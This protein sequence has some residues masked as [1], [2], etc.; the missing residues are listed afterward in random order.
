MILI[1]GTL[2]RS[3][4]LLG[5]ACLAG[6]GFAG[7]AFAERPD[8]VPPEQIAAPQGASPGHVAKMLPS[9]GTADAEACTENGYAFLEGDQVPQNEVRAFGYFV[10]GC[11]F[12]SMRGCTMAG[13][14]Y[15]QGQGVV[16]NPAYAASYYHRACE[17]GEAI[18]SSNLGLAYAGGVG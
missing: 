8:D 11:E 6:T 7:L 9:C 5:L 1:D 14:A 4:L 2:R 13:Y 18:A 16:A 10:Q 15:A 12:G 17:G 3:F